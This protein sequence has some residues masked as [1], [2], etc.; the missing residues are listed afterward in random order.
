MTWHKFFKLKEGDI[1]VDL[2][3]YIG[4]TVAFYSK[5]VGKTGLVI[6]LEPDKDN[7]HRLEQMIK[8]RKLSNVVPLL[9]A[10]GKNTGIVDLR[11]TKGDNAHS[12]VLSTPRFR[13]RKRRVYAISWDDLMDAFALDHVDLVKVNVEGAEIEFLEGMS[14]VFPEKIALDE[15]SRFGINLKHLMK[16]LKDQK[17]LL[18]K[19]ASTIPKHDN[20]LYLK[21]G[22]EKPAIRISDAVLEAGGRRIVNYLEVDEELKSFFNT[23]EFYAEYDV[24]VSNVPLGILNIPALS[25]IIHFAWA[26][27]C[28]VSLGEIDET[29]LQGLEKVRKVLG[30]HPGYESLKFTTSIKPSKIVK[31]KFDNLKSKGLFFSGGCDSTAAYIKYRED[32]PKLITVWGL[33]IPTDWVKLWRKVIDQYKGMNILKIKTNTEDMYSRSISDGID[34]LGRSIPEGYRPGYSFSFNTFGV[35]APLTVVEGI[36]DLMLSST[37]PSREYD[38]PEHPWSNKRPNHIIDEYMG[39][40]NVKTRDVL[41]EYSTNEKVKHIIKPYFEEHGPMFLR[42]CG[43]RVYLEK[44]KFKRLN[45]LECDKCE[46]VIGM[47]IV[48][49]VDPNTC[50]FR[51]FHDTFDRIK[52]DIQDKRW[53]PTYLSYHWQEIREQIPKEI[54]QNFGGSHWF[55]EW[56]RNYEL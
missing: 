8:K 52:S 43:F 11:L 31:N 5:A 29:Y 55:L 2:G 45:C 53:N 6:A 17:Y 36:G 32:N 13:H 46:R 7:Y 37:Y 26:V 24:D 3:A 51:I 20:I 30:G 21:R 33:D 54:D 44:H 23:A 28:D 40:A 1:V 12:T 56:L 15:H 25:S 27:G 16:L 48:N 38:D 4:E 10:I 22:T 39:W 47:L 49:G 35:A 34:S 50:G 9:M 42:S 41:C 19:K 18:I 14:H